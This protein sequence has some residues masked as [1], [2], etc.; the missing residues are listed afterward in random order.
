MLNPLKE[1]EEISMLYGD[2]NK[3]IKFSNVDGPGNRMAIFLQK[4]NFNCKYCHNPETINICINCA[5]C[6]EKCPTSSLTFQDKK[7]IW[8]A[9]SCIHCDLCLK[10]CS[11]NS[12]PKIKKMSVSNLIIE[13]EKLKPF[14]TGVTISGGECTLHYEYITEF[15]TEVK[16][17]W[18]QL[19]CFIDTNG[20]VDLSEKK[21][22]KFIEIT[23][24]FMLD[25]KAWNREEHITLTGSDNKSVLKNL[26]FLKQIEK[27]YEVRTVVIDNILNNKLTV[28]KVSNI[29]YDSNIIYKIIKYRSIGV[30]D[31]EKK[32]LIE[33][34]DKKLITLAE[35][36]KKIGVKC[37][38]II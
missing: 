7:V 34:N 5:L 3:I 38:F 22:G 2:I 12:S 35:I 1:K 36:S 37:V 16:R 28:S 17:R 10:A 13:V 26:N 19:T 14:I 32:N 15:F 6:I 29:I 24:Y 31:K 21:Y 25:I 11:I 23:D 33:P 30:R 9:S 18:S 20:G 27:L 8:N 4:C